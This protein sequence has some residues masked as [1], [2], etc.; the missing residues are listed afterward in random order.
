MFSAR[1]GWPRDDNPLKQATERVRSTTDFIDLTVS[2]P[3]AVDLAYDERRILAALAHSGALRY[4]P[5]PFG[6]ES[7]REAVSAYYKR[8][9]IE[10]SKDRIILV[11]T[12]SEAYSFLFRLLVD[13]GDSVLVPRPSYPLFSYLADLADVQLEPY[14]LR[15]LEPEG[16][17]LDTDSFQ[18]AL[19]EA[20]RAIIT[21]TP[22][23]PTGSTSSADERRLM[24]NLAATSDVA[25]ISDEVFLDYV[26]HP[27]APKDAS[28]VGI[29][30][31]MCF[32]MSGISKIAGL[33][34][35]KLSW[36]VATGPEDRL[37]EALARLEIIADTFL[38]LAAPIQHALPE[39]LD[40]AETWQA[41]LRDRIS[42]NRKALAELLPE[43]ARLRRSEGGWY[44]ILDL[45]DTKEDEAWAIELLDAAHVLL[46]PGYLFDIEED[47]ALVAS[48]ILR[49]DVFRE[50]IRRLVRHIDGSKRSTST[51]RAH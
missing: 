2:N 47:S 13:P 43:T 18:E 51:P 21:V 28:L 29:E 31:P 1:T 22:N 4:E 6:L 19:H 48:L 9:G 32:S 30:G 10:V 37:G 15:Y 7:A 20:T 40:V 16:W 3:T 26:T 38:S 36:I 35:L 50:G 25:L 17:R 33:P 5:K 8:R 39:L 27:A 46:H 42:E 12:T 11:A 44:A 49:P 14:H 45:P 41:G 34:Q 23:N 24:A